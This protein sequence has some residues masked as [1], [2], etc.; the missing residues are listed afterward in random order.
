MSTN[1]D[2][3]RMG[4]DEM[5]WRQAAIR[6]YW[7]FFVPPAFRNPEER[8]LFERVEALS[9][10]MPPPDDAP[11]ESPTLPLVLWFAEEMEKKLA[12]NRHKGGPAA[13]RKDDPFDLASRVRRETDELVVAMRDWLKHGDNTTTGDIIK[14][15]ADVANFAMMIADQAKQAGAAQQEQTEGTEAR[16]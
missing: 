1:I 11:A 4:A 14:E 2:D 13:W 6:L 7:K 8:E 10:G 12:L 16:P 3:K 9:A 15:A 5:A